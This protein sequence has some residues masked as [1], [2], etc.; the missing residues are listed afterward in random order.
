MA[1]RTSGSTSRELRARVG[2]RSHRGGISKLDRADPTVGYVTR[3]YLIPEMR[4]LG[5]GAELDEYARQFF[6]QMGLSRARL[7]VS[8][9]NLQAW[10]FYAKSG[11][12]D[13]GPRQEMPDVHLLENSNHVRA[14]Q[15]PRRVRGEAYSA[16][17]GN[18]P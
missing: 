1:R 9:T 16:H 11:W 13:V 7:S 3:F 17:G 18:R 10:R 5:L 14:T 6:A 4:N 8:P 15:R 2:K 12:V